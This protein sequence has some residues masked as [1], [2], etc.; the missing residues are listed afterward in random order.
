ME[1]SATFGSWVVR[2]TD[3]L[4]G[5]RG[6]NVLGLRER[7]MFWTEIM[8]D[9][10]ANHAAAAAGERSRQSG[11][12]PSGPQARHTVR[13]RASNDADHTAR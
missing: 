10:S 7:R 8:R 3:Y 13:P 9:G 4:G 1:T 11:I 2:E 12:G 6:S 5:A